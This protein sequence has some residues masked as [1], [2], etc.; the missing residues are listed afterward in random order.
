MSKNRLIRLIL[1]S[2]NTLLSKNWWANQSTRRRPWLP[3]G[4]QRP[5]CH[6]SRH[7]LEEDCPSEADHDLLPLQL[8][9]HVQDGEQREEAETD[10]GDD[11]TDAGND[12][13][14]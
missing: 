10:H 11:G 12:E 9:G 1:F 6:S 4:C 13:P 2:D 8:H 14:C 3:A 7:D 5:T